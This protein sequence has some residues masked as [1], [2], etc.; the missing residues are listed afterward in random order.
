MSSSVDFD[1]THN[2][3]QLGKDEIHLWCC[4]ETAIRDDVL[5]QH[6]M[7]WLNEVELGRFNRFYFARHRHQFL[8]AR[9]LVRF[10]LSSYQPSLS[11]GDWYF[12]ANEYGRPAIANPGMPDGSLEFNLTHTPGMAV[13]ALCHAGELGVDVE[14]Q[15][16]STDAT[17]LADRFFSP[18]EARK[19]KA[20]PEAQRK[21]RF[22]DL[23]TLKES[24]I[25]A[26][27]M[28][29]AI[30]L[31]S[32]SFELSSPGE[33]GFGVEPEAGDRAE[34]WQFWQVRPN[35]THKIAVAHRMG[36]TPVETRLKYFEVV[37]DVSVNPVDYTVF[38]SSRY[39]V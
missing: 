33:I 13:L 22:F 32:F 31:G 17:L 15:L 38:S 16:R 29:L 9:A 3:P 18:D 19:L 25:K 5:L 7:T 23:W 6:Y 20:L 28:G 10:A 24:Y 37:P 26:R 30:P 11:P 8:V 2:L 36:D 35:A 1:N 34:G 27:G 4:D 12:N 14:Y 39:C 21:D